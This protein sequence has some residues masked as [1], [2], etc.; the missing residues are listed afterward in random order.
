M[1]CPLCCEPCKPFYINLEEQI[2]L[3]SNKSCIYPFTEDNI[4]NLDVFAS[5]S[6]NENTCNSHHQP[7]PFPD[8]KQE[9]SKCDIDRLLLEIFS[10][11]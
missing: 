3:C 10:S 2:I 7:N 6:E 5:P 11:K 8:P 9:D 1:E 4:P